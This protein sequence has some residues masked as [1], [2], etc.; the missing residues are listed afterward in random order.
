MDARA[1]MPQGPSH[2]ELCYIYIFIYIYIW[3]RNYYDSERFVLILSIDHKFVTT[4]ASRY[5]ISDV[6]DF[7]DL[8]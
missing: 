2:L 8:C 1:G 3:K 7:S 4:Y 5:I 6:Y